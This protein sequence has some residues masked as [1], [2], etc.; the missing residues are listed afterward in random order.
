MA[1]V[2]RASILEALSKHPSVPEEVRDYV[3]DTASGLVDDI[4]KLDADSIAAELLDAIAP[5]LEGSIPESTI[6][7]LCTKVARA[8]KGIGEN[9]AGGPEK[10]EGTADS[11][12]DYVV[13]CEGIILAY[14]GKSLLRSTSLHLKRGRCYGI[15]GHNGVGKTTLL[16]RIAAGDIAG[17]PQDIRCVYVQHEI[18][19]NDEQNVLDYMKAAQARLGD[20]QADVDVGAVL[21]QMGFTDAL[22]SKTVMELS[23]GWRMRLALAGAILRGADLLLLDEPTNH[24]DV[25]AV[26]WLVQYLRG[27]ERTT[28]LIVSHDYKCAAPRRRSPLSSNLFH[29]F[30]ERRRK[31]APRDT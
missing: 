10:A 11:N 21:G 23:G 30:T 17:F 20:G 1:E 7:E 25:D 15:V 16:T 6:S 22:Q 3:V 4:Q 13:K 31:L 24:L 27:L 5:L 12:E 9:E 14:A 26:A 2:L 28:V 8:F 18:L 29:P 19:A